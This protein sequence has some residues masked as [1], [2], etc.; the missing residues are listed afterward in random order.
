MKIKVIVFLSIALTSTGVLAQPNPRP[1][2]QNINKEFIKEFLKTNP[3][4]RLMDETKDELIFTSPL[5]N[6]YYPSGGYTPDKPTN[7]HSYTIN[8]KNKTI[9]EMMIEPDCEDQTFVMSM[10]DSKGVFRYL[11]WN[12]K[13]PVVFSEAFCNSTWSSQVR[14]ARK[15][16]KKVFGLSDSSNERMPKK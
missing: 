1:F 4:Y 13:M 14:A 8:K 7:F 9:D 11:V 16:V 5:P 3:S 6:K 2:N 10:P 15:E 12:E